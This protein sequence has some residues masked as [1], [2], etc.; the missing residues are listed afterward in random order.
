MPIIDI[1]GGASA[2]SGVSQSR[3]LAPLGPEGIYATSVFSYKSPVQYKGIR[4]TLRMGITPGR[5]LIVIH[6]QE[7]EPIEAPVQGTGLAAV[8]KARSMIDT[9]LKSHEGQ[10]AKNAN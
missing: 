1:G 8:L 2:N 4:Y 10:V 9:W 5:W 3:R 7:Q 6:P